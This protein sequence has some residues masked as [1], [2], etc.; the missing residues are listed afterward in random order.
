MS[1]MQQGGA[2]AGNP[3]MMGGGF[4]GVY[5]QQ[6]QA[7]PQQA[8]RDRFASQL[9]TIKDMGFYDE[10]MILQALGGTNGNVN[11]V[12]ERLLGSM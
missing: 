4:P 3:Y 11:A 10:D 7:Q 1:G 6:P 2:G 9:Q 8:P 12:V 5:P